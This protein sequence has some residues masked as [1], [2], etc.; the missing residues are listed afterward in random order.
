MSS[1]GPQT[2]NFCPAGMMSR[3]FWHEGISEGDT[4]SEHCGRPSG[5]RTKMSRFR[6]L[7]FLESLSITAYSKEF[8]ASSTD[9]TTHRPCALSHPGMASC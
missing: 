7:P 5:L 6:S 1:A 8:P 4:L 2:S 3:R 9:V